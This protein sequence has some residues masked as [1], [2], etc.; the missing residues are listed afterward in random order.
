MTL[1]RKATIPAVLLSL[2][3]VLAGCI[4]EAN[5]ER[6]GD[7]GGDIGNWA[8][9]IV[10]HGEDDVTNRIYYETPYMGQGIERSQDARAD[11]SES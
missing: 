1:N 9:D 7:A 11:D 4:P 2:T 10:M 3:F 6:G 8:D 5:R